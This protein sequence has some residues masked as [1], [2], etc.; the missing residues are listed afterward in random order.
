MS[1]NPYEPATFVKIE[2]PDWSKNATI[3]QIN[4]RQ[5]T[6]EGTL[7]AAESHLPRLKELG[8]DILWLMPI[9]PIGEKNRKGTLGSPY[10]V[11]DYLAVNPEFGDLDDLLQLREGLACPKVLLDL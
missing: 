4:L 5:F 7:R 8:A 1:A 3:Y 11:Q 9:H 10:S 2:H 6:A